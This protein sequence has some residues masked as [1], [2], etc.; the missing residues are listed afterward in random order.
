MRPDLI[1]RYDALDVF[2][3]SIVDGVINGLSNRAGLSHQPAPDADCADWDDAGSAMDI[4]PNLAEIKRDAFK[5]AGI[6]TA[7]T[8][9]DYVIHQTRLPG[10]WGGMTFGDI[11][12]K[13]QDP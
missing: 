13:K 9:D 4:L 2:D 6:T 3:R 7:A 8:P 5:E 1:E 10:W 12:A 11:M